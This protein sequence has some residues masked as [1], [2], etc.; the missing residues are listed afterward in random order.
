[1]IPIY[2]HFYE[3]SRG[4]KPVLDYIKKQIN[5]I[6]EMSDILATLEDIDD[7][8]A[9]YL[10]SGEENTRCLGEG[11]F[12]LK[13]SKHRLYYIYCSGNRVYMLHACYKQKGKAGQKDLAI[14]KKRMKIIEERERK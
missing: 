10:R 4:D 2:L 13:M 9:K 1:M 3:T 7:K 11:L 12:E 6:N 5:D 8:G 14:G